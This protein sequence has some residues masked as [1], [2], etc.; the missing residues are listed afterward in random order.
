MARICRLT[1]A[2]GVG[3]QVDIEL[4]FTQARAIREGSR[5]VGDTLKLGLGCNVLLDALLEPS[6][7]L[8]HEP[9]DNILEDKSSISSPGV[10]V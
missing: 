8:V 9:V 1:P 3:A 5:G 10:K 6:V 2:T 4:G 7:V